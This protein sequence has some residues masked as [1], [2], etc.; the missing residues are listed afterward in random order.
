MSSKF[1]RAG[2]APRA[3]TLSAIR[4]SRR[5]LV[6]MVVLPMFRVR[7]GRNVRDSELPF[8][9]GQL[10]QIDGTDDVYDGELFRF[11]GDD[12]KS[13]DG[14]AARLGVD[15]DVFARAA[16]DLHDLFPGRSELLADAGRFRL[17]VFAFV[18]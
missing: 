13:G 16:G 17:V 9:A 12:Q 3:K 8:Q 1:A 7:A 6:M 11:C 18:V 4:S 5:R 14:V 10:F 15:V 2:V